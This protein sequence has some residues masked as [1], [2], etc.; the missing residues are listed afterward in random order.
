MPDGAPAPNPSAN[1]AALR[2]G[3]I[4]S[5]TT[6]QKL[7]PISKPNSRYP[8]I[9]GSFHRSK[10]RPVSHAPIITKPRTSIL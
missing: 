8:L 2:P 9:F 4:G 7:G 3:T 5:S 10:S 1:P 6:S